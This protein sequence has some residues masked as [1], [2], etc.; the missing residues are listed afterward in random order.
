MDLRFDHPPREPGIGNSRVK[1]DR[2]KALYSLLF[3]PLL[4]VGTV[5]V[6]FLNRS[7]KLK[8]H[9]KPRKNRY[10]LKAGVQKHREMG[11]LVESH[12]ILRVAAADQLFQEKL[13]RCT[14]LNGTLELYLTYNKLHTFKV[15]QFRKF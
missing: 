1:T 4:S 8:Y 2:A 14:F 10:I 15:L 6:C 9:W 11:D 3:T 5:P 13:A 7:C 12:P